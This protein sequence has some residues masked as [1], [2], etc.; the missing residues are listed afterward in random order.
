MAKDYDILILGGGPAGLTAGLYAAR[1]RLKTGIIEQKRRP[2]GQAATTWGIEN[3]P[4]YSETTGAELAEALT[5]HVKKFGCHIIRDQVIH[6]E[7]GSYYK[8]VSCKKEEYRSKAIII[9]TGAE[10]RTLG[11]K[12]ESRLRGRGVSY[13]ATCDADFYTDQEVV[14]LG[15]GDAA[16]E[17]AI[18]LTR[19]AAQVTIIVIHNEGKMDATKIIQE[20]AYNN[21]KISFLWNSVVE[22]IK[23]EDIIESVVVKNIK[24]G[25]MG[26]VSTAG[27]FI[28]VGTVPR[29]DIFEDLVE[30]SKEGYI[31]TDRSM[32]TS[33]PGVFAAGDITEKTL[34]QV[35]TA[36]ADGAVAATAAERYV[37]A[38]DEFR[39]QILKVSQKKPVIVTFYSP[40]VKKSL[41]AIELIENIFKDEKEYEIAYVDTYKNRRIADR[42]HVQAIPEIMVFEEGEVTLSLTGSLTREDIEKIIAR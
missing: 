16:V 24:T 2:G 15:N 18:Y 10:P 41:D 3:Y 31:K 17:E 26:E 29:S 28:F 22:E 7:L 35:V 36:C 8:M 27:I 9:A 5:E 20:K 37:T 30:M 23:G 34:R 21:P 38:E 42:Y 33:V 40:T 1:A 25:E 12:G 19:Y 11:I 39:E 14:V 13:C 4:G 6:V 32:E